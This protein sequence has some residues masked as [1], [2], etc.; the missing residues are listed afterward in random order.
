MRVSSGALFIQESW[1]RHL[2]GRKSDYYFQYNKGNL[3]Q[4]GVVIRGIRVAV[5]DSSVA[6]Y[7]SV[8][9][10]VLSNRENCTCRN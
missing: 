7:R 3:R 2:S 1:V 9:K 8:V 5:G 4:V 10:H 6:D